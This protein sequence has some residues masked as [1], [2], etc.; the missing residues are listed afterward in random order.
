MYIVENVN[1]TRAYSDVSFSIPLSPS[2]S[3]PWREA[4]VSWVSLK[5]Y[6]VDM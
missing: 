1:S 4:T 2:P 5:R 3:V 6:S